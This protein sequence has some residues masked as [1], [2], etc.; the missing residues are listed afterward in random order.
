MSIE[1]E[2]RM[3]VEDET[4]AAAT[5]KVN[6]FLDAVRSQVNSILEVITHDGR[7]VQSEMNGIGNHVIVE[8]LR[9]AADILDDIDD[10]KAAEFREL[11]AKVKRWPF[12]MIEKKKADEGYSAE[13]DFRL[14]AQEL[15]LLEA[16]A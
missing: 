13:D 1:N 4:R 5:E 7:S 11:A 6:H 9:D 3:G 14:L 8:A 10:E 2:A 15:L 12:D 16:E